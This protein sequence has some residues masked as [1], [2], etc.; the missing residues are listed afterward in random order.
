M[1]PPTDTD[2]SPEM[3]PQPGPLARRRAATDH[4][5]LAMAVAVAALGAL[6]LWSALLARGPGRAEFLRDVVHLPLLVAHGSRT[7]IALFGLGLLMLAR[8]LARRKRQAWRLA[9]LLAGAS[10]FLHLT[11]G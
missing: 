7:L 6:N 9:L 8:S 1:T 2:V 3:L 10:P 11:K 5:V 4:A